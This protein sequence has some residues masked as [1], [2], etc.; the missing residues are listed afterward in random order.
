MRTRAPSKR[1]TVRS[2]PERAAYDSETI[3]AILDRG[4]ICH[5]GFVID[6]QPFVIP[7]IY[8]RCNRKVV[9]H[10][11]PGSRML[12]AAKA[13]APL[14]VTVTLYDGLVLARSAFK[15]SINYRSVVILGAASEITDESQKLTA[16]EALV[17]HVMPGRWKEIRRPSAAELKATT[18]LAVPVEEASAKIRCGPPMDK[19]EDYQLDV[20][21]GEIPLQTVASAPRPDPRL[22]SDIP[23]PVHIETFLN[24]NRKRIGVWA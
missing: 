22:P 19:D 23:L 12:R 17:E 8:A 7:T 4:L 15:H 16:L 18:I 14:C 3:D 20:W 24:A 11:S 6:S 2:R 5:V 9:I 13:G 10:G 1:A 21:A